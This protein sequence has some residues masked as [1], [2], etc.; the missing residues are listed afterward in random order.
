MEVPNLCIF[1]SLGFLAFW[2]LINTI[3]NIFLHGNVCINTPYKD[4]EYTWF[5]EYI[6]TYVLFSYIYIYISL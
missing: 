2:S 6:Y 5:Y 3:V 4:T 1:N